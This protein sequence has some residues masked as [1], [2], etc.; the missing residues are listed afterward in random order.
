MSAF[1]WRLKNILRPAYVRGWKA[2]IRI[3]ERP[4]GTYPVAIQGIQ[5]SGTNFLTTL[6]DN[7]DYRVLNRIDPKRND[8]RH[9]HCR[10]QEDKSTIVM[11]ERFRNSVTAS[12]IDEVNE[13][14]RY[15]ADMQHIVLFR[16]PEKWL[17]SI[18]RWGLKN[19]WF[20]SED[21]FF[22]RGL[23]EAFLR[24][25][26]EYYAFWQ[27]MQRD[28]SKR[29]L[30]LSHEDLVRSPTEGLKRIE[31]FSGVVRAASMAP[32]GPVKKVRHSR[33]IGERRKDLD[34]EELRDVLSLP[35]HFDWQAYLEKV[36][37]S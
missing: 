23:H 8:P 31:A 18:F 32:A 36:P 5:R 19:E 4:K 29:V 22:E 13:I 10:W 12:S 20:S 1:N 6:L 15:P 17:N 26:D 35:T 16:A 2:W 9:K 34:R 11:D 28:D 37:Q 30:I 14:C 24:E 25:W 21:A 7:A 3:N 27:D 33:P